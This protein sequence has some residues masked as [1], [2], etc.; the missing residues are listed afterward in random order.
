MSLSKRGGW[1]SL[2]Y[3]LLVLCAGGLLAADNTWISSIDSS[4]LNPSRWFWSASA[5]DSAVLP[6]AVNAPVDLGPGARLSMD[7]LL[8]GL[9][10]DRPAGRW[11]LSSRTSDLS[12]SLARRLVEFDQINPRSGP[13]NFAAYEMAA[14]W[15]P[16]VAA[17]STELTHAPAGPQS[18]SAITADGTWRAD[19]SGNWSD[20]TKWG[21][22]V[23]ADGAG[24]SAF[25]NTL[26]ITTNVTVTLDTSRTIGSLLIA[27]LNATHKYTIGSS[28]GSTLTFDNAGSNSSLEQMGGSAGD[29]ISA[30][31]LVNND[32]DIN[33]FSA[34]NQFTISGN[35]A[36]SAT[37]GFGQTLWFNPSGS[38]RILVS[39]NISNG[40]T[41][42]NINVVVVG[43]TVTLTGTNSYTGFTSVDG[44]TLLI[45]GNNSGATA[46]VSVGSGGTLGGIG[47]VGGNV[48]TFGGTITGATD[49]TVGTLTLL[50]NVNLA[51]HEGSG[52]YLANLS[53]N[54]SDLLAITG[55]LHLGDGSILNI[56]G[57]GDGVTT[58][59]L[60]TFSGRTS[61]PGEMA[62]FE[63]VSGIPMGYNL[64]YHDMDIQLVPIPEPA[65]WIG[66]ALLVGALLFTQRRRFRRA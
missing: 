19:A 25:F 51:T 41:G 49:T 65:T 59:T 46:S 48:Q 56:Q 6:E 43:G 2:R 5:N 9:L 14:S 30:P 8:N 12:S 22:G 15:A 1:R 17:P 54:M 18:P 4:I 28:G 55:T 45:N 53:G 62:F 61:D 10:F 7:G 37:S 27:D 33:N 26:D 29:T 32:L 13:D 42:Q 63:T 35:I 57:I 38:G 39:G 36:S 21:S 23:V 34:A 3:L 11:A 52:T 20:S 24:N 44:G 64:V 58:Y 50:G 16:V 40:S 31:I 66:G 47:T 60:A